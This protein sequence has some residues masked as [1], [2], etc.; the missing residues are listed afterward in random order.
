MVAA[1]V[2]FS[3]DWTLLTFQPLE[4]SWVATPRPAPLY[5]VPFAC[6]RSGPILCMYFVANPGATENN[7]LRGL[8]LICSFISSK[9]C[10]N[11]TFPDH[12]PSNH[13]PPLQPASHPSSPGAIYARPWSQC[14]TYFLSPPIESTPHRSRGLLVL[15]LES[16]ATDAG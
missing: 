1:E 13:R 8:S 6:H 3:P 10:S 16:G 5:N 14:L 2:H 15:L 4:P 7:L 9:L 12:P 11:I